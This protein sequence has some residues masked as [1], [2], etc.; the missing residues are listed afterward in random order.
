MATV[1]KIVNNLL[2]KEIT[3]TTFTFAYNTYNVPLN[4]I[5]LLLT[6]GAATFQSLASGGQLPSGDIISMPL[7]VPI[8]L[9]ASNNLPIGNFQVVATAGTVLMVATATCKG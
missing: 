1:I 9:S 3:N 4:Q 6:S 7:N 2:S 5:S 8:N